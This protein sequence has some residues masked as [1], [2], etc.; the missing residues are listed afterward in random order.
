MQRSPGTATQ[1]NDPSEFLRNLTLK[2]VPHRDLARY[3]LFAVDAVFACGVTL[4][5]ADAGTIKA[6]NAANRAS[7]NPLVPMFDPDVNDLDESNIVGLIGRDPTGTIVTA[8]AIRLYDWRSS[9]YVR[10][11]QSL[12]L[13]YRDPISS[14]LEGESCSIA[15][16]GASSISGRCAFSGA[17]WVHPDYRHLGLG[18]VLP[19]FIKVLGTCEWL[20]DIVFGMMSENVYR[21]GFST[22]FGFDHEAGQATWSNSSNGTLRLAILW[23]SI[24]SVAK[25]AGKQL[26]AAAPQIDTR[27]LNRGPK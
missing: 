22:R 4:Q 18:Q 15:S 26:L 12:K 13:M 19:V 1:T 14:A 3:V 20:P 9:N 24:D 2:H 6:A 10:E 8:N 5:F 25:H 7:W 11:A 23:T 27:V 16:D 21:R 17:A